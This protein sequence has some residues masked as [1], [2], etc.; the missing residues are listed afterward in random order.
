[1]WQTVPLLIRYGRLIRT[2]AFCEVI[3]IHNAGQQRMS[4]EFVTGVETGTDGREVGEAA[5][6]TARSKLDREDVD[7]CQVFCSPTYDL[8][9]VIEG[10]RAVV[11][12]RTELIGCTSA[13][14]FTEAGTTAGSVTLA[15]VSSDTHKF[16]TGFGTGLAA[17]VDE[18]L[19]EAVAELP[20]RVE[21]YPHLSAINLHDGLQGVG[22][23]V[24]IATQRA[25]GQHV[26]FAGGSA[27]D[28]MQMD[29]TRVFCNDQIAE[30]AV[31]LGLVASKEPVPITVNHGH[32]PIS[33]SLEVTRAEGNTVYELDGRPAFEVWLDVVNE[34]AKAEYGIDPTTLADGSEDLSRLLTAYEFGID[35]GTDYKIRWPGLTTT[36]DGPIEFAV[37]IPEGTV[38]RV[39][40]SPP[41]D[42]IE[43]AVTAV[44]D[45][46]REL[47]DRQVAGAFI[48]DCVC[49]S[50]ILGEEFANSI[51]AITDELDAPLA[52]FETYGELCMERGQIGG[53]HNTTSVVFL[54]PE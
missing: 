19:R 37:S 22:E 9:A 51:T 25:L 46:K 8:S 32:K 4:S 43:S 33:E 21:G 2:V 11:G 26:G 49:R 18:C 12:D 53:Y 7:F 29:T 20:S 23:Q 40:H 50:A 45:A 30:N 41:D 16:F 44:R 5:A 14:E 15:L 34:R 24:A 42:Q 39:M 47:G 48:Y 52:G 28:D 1:M 17:D 6:T 54:L 27:G 3:D 31:A 13:G 38:L 36:T 35:Q 10:I